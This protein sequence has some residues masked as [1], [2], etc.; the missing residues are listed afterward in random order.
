[1]RQQPVV[2]DLGPVGKH[3]WRHVI[4]R[5]LS[6][7]RSGSLWHSE[8]HNITKHSPTCLLH[9]YTKLNAV[10]G[11]RDLWFPTNFDD[12]Q[13][14]LFIFIYHHMSLKK[15]MQLSEVPCLTT[16]GTPKT[17]K[18][19]Q[20]KRFQTTDATNLK[21]KNKTQNVEYL[22]VHL[23]LKSS[24][25]KLFILHQS[26]RSYRYTQMSIPSSCWNNNAMTL[27]TW[28]SSQSQS[29]GS[30]QKQCRM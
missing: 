30:L 26:S 11:F 13:Q 28:F 4:N 19:E 17:P 12:L 7:T 14:D 23:S 27:Y 20:M 1:M 18:F 5:P 22:Q 24:H 10:Y 25:P 16:N 29:N 2:L 8:V 9:V 6:E 3:Q 15:P 21:R